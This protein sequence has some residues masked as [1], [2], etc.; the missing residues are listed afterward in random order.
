MSEF[1]Y[2]SENGDLYGLGYTR[3]LDS[4]ANKI[5]P[6]KIIASKEVGEPRSFI[7]R[8]LR[9]YKK[10]R[11][12]ETTFL[13]LSEKELTDCKRQFTDESNFPLCLADEVSIAMNG[14]FLF[15]FIGFLLPFLFSKMLIFS[16][17]TAIL[18]ASLPM[19]ILTILGNFG[20]YD[21]QDLPRFSTISNRVKGILIAISMDSVCYV[22][23]NLSDFSFNFQSKSLI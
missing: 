6:G 12:P 4:Q 9:R 8:W 10:K 3:N 16:F 17:F 18:S 19:W 7:A 1:T 15:G 11:I 14:A 20:G 5:K 22:L 21:I 2:L 13:R 23:F